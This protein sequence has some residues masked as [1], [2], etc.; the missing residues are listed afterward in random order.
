MRW[1]IRM[2]R[3]KRSSQLVKID[4]DGTYSRFQKRAMT[5]W[6]SVGINVSGGQRQ[7][8]C[9]ALALPWNPK[10]LILDD[11]T[12]AVDTK[13][14]RFD[15]S[16]I[17][18]PAWKRLP[19][20]SLVSGFPLFK[21]QIASSWWMMAKSMPS[22]VTRNCLRPMP[23]TKSIWNANTKGKEK[24]MKTRKSKSRL[25]PSPAR[26]PLEK[27]YKVSLIVSLYLNHSIVSYDG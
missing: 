6:L 22:V 5:L 27:N 8:L 26:L 11:S 17:G 24:Q 21:M 10:I 25:Y 23:S 18:Q 16:R 15:P 12:S 9:I 2:R 19:K 1:E 14:D 3:M 7:R 4:A 13:T 20:S